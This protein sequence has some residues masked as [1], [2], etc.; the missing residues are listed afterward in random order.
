MTISCTKI[1]REGG[2]PEY[3]YPLSAR[4]GPTAAP[5]R[6][7]QPGPSASRPKAP[8]LVA[9]EVQWHRAAD[10]ERLGGHLGDPGD[11]DEQRQQ[12]QA[13]GLGNEADDQ[14]ADGL[15]VG[16]IA[17]RVERPV[18]VEDE[19]VAHRDQPGGD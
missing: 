2:R 10:R 7:R 16:A 18:A 12:Q 5:G 13:D 6:V 8:Q 9:Q 14:E 11:L 19:V 1:L 15:A 3:R 4:N 17:S